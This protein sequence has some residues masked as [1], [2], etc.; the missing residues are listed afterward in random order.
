MKTAQ[1]LLAGATIYALSIPFHERFRHSEADRAACD[2]VAVRVVDAEGNEG[3]GEGAP[4]P[5][6]TGETVATMLADLE[7]AWPAI[8][9]TPVLRLDGPQDLTLLQADLPAG[10]IPG[11]GGAARAA[12]ELA[13]LDC[14]LRRDGR[15]LSSLLPARRSTVRYS[16]VIS[17]GSAERAR[18]TASIFRTFGITQVKVKVGFDGD[19]DNVRAVRDALGPDASIRADANGAWQPDEALR[20]IA[21][22]AEL[23][24]ECV[25]Q[26]LPRTALAELVA[27]RA[28]SPLPLMADESLV[29]IADARELAATGAVDHFNLR[30]S[31]CGGLSRCVAIAAI[32]RDAGIGVQVGCQVGETAILSAAGRHLAAGLD[33]LLYA[34]GSFGEALLL[35]DLG[36]VPVMF[37]LGGAAPQLTGPGLGVE[38][39]AQRV[40][41][42]A[43]QTVELRGGW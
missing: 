14:V 41:R 20:A 37:G 23:G 22:L 25:E 17:A 18:A 38:I 30:V 5:Y 11:L 8:A 12:I 21:G 28:R 2:S 19:L 35:Q 10:P 32:A 24:V 26:P 7:A 6:V 36:R 31:K 27:L 3:W 15:P 34:E 1:R 13:V 40:S 9:T 29:T 39:D 42:W 16:G 43:K 4:R 33:Q